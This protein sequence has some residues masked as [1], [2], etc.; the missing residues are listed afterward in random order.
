MEPTNL[1]CPRGPS[2]KPK[3][4]NAPVDISCIPS[5]AKKIDRLKSEKLNVAEKETLAIALVKLRTATNQKLNMM[6]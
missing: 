1:R 5:C 2:P 6:K 4:A 3:A